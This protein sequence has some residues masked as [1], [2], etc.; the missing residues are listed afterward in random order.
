[1]KKALHI[2]LPAVLVLTLSACATGPQQAAPETGNTQQQAEI[3]ELKDSRLEPLVPF[4]NELAA[5]TDEKEKKKLEDGLSSLVPIL[6]KLGSSP[7]SQKNLESLL[8][9]CVKGQDGKVV[10]TMYQ[11]A[12]YEFGNL[13]ALGDGRKDFTD[14]VKGIIEKVANRDKR[15]VMLPPDD[16][17]NEDPHCGDGDNC[18]RYELENPWGIHSSV[19]SMLDDDI[20]STAKTTFGEIELGNNQSKSFKIPVT[21]GDECR[22]RR[23]ARA[24][25]DYNIVAGRSPGGIESGGVCTRTF[26]YTPEAEKAPGTGKVIDIAMYNPRTGR[27]EW[28]EKQEITAS[29]TWD[30]VKKVCDLKRDAAGERYVMIVSGGG[31]TPRVAQ[32]FRV[33]FVLVDN[34]ISEPPNHDYVPGIFGKGQ[35]ACPPNSWGRPSG[36][37]ER[38]LLEKIAPDG[39]IPN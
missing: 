18:V 10:A 25:R 39:C 12:T 5:V 38:V 26:E 31:T 35:L 11:K 4:L 37:L 27:I 6:A 14:R 13:N 32:Y 8:S 17:A 19:I 36:E 3:E 33:E 2:T 21:L 15:T 23:F 1:M 30:R 22:P 9:E 29:G 34:E 16:M 28:G 24:T 7:E 20:E